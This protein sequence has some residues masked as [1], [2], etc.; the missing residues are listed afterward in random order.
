[1][2]GLNSR[3]VAIIVVVFFA[4]SLI[5]LL[6]LSRYIHPSTDD[7]VFGADTYHAILSGGNTIGS[8]IA[9][10][11]ST[12]AR[13]YQ[14]WQGTYSAC[15]LM[16]LQPGVFDA[17]WVTPFILIF[18]YVFATYRLMYVVLRK[19]FKATKT[20]YVIIATT[21]LLMSIQFVA[22]TYD[23]FYW[24]N[25]AIYYT[26]YYSVGLLFFASLID[27]YLN[28][29]R[30]G[31]KIF[32]GA[33]SSVLCVF[34]A[35]GNYVTGLAIPVILFLT[36]IAMYRY[37]L[38]IPRLYY[39]M[40]CLFS[41][42][43]IISMAAPGNSVRAATVEEGTSAVKAIAISFT[44][45]TYY[46]AK[47]TNPTVCALFLFLT[48]ILCNIAKRSRFSFGN[49]L[50]FLAVTYAVYCVFFVPT[51][52]A[53]GVAGYGRIFNVY[54]YNYC[55][56]MLANIF[57]F[58]GYLYKSAGRGTVISNDVLK[59]LRD[60]KSKVLPYSRYAYLLIVGLLTVTIVQ[61]SSASKEISKFIYTGR[62]AKLDEIMMARE[63]HYKSG[64]ENLILKPLPESL[65]TMYPQDVRPDA[66][67][68][69]NQGIC[70]YY[71]K[72]TVACADTLSPK[73]RLRA[74]TEF[75]KE[76]GP[77]NLVYKEKF[78]YRKK[79]TDDRYR[80]RIDPK[81]KKSEEEL[82]SYR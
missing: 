38:R 52:Y 67:H 76:V 34:L 20:Q 19:I 64:K 14:D 47:F 59:L 56:F 68:W 32:Y 30:M 61:S 3:Y 8:A 36:I 77:G 82:I 13:M 39:V 24:Y 79:K 35:G 44:N 26:F 41:V 25:G 74:E 1:M 10:A 60:V 51:C 46:L 2:K 7:F 33:V 50:L 49:P 40:L 18:G 55:W 80:V 58:A 15:F 22:S 70:M 53:L 29:K 57:Y 48:P 17:Y 42:A 27:Y 9:A 37:K 16:A 6:L 4:I 54:E 28:R 12:A 62:A 73:E 81:S 75:R 65:T 66:G 69:I 45:G 78:Q 31:L 5:P 21:F 11:A 23:A 72:N 71:G 63:R 43:F